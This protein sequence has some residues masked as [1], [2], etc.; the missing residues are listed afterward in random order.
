MSYETCFRNP[1]LLFGGICCIS[2]INKSLK[3]LLFTIEMVLIANRN[4]SSDEH[5]FSHFKKQQRTDALHWHLR[6]SP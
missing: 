6:Q 3:N 1:R 5:L 4:L 2:R